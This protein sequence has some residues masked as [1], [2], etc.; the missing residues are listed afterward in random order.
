MEYEDK[1]QKMKGICPIC[2]Q[3]DVEMYKLTMLGNHYR[4]G[5]TGKELEQKVSFQWVEK[6]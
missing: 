1:P 2:G 3:E 4:C 6:K 5:S